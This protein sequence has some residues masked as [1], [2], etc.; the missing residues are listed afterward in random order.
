MHKIMHI[1][2][3]NRLIQHAFFPSFS[4]NLSYNKIPPKL[5]HKIICCIML[6]VL[7]FLFYSGGQ[8]HYIAVVELQIHMP[9]CKSMLKLDIRS[10]LLV[11]NSRVG[12]VFC[13]NSLPV[14]HLLFFKKWFLKN[15]MYESIQNIAKTFNLITFSQ[16]KLTSIT[17]GMSPG[18][19]EWYQEQI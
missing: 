17:E 11:E 18:S 12:H 7:K 6:S 2:W 3:E 4:T 10:F 1:Q 8:K 5:T 16:C 15:V 14:L 13:S 19:Q 9:L